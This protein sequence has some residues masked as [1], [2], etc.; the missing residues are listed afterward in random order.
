VRDSSSTRF[1]RA[2]CAHAA[3]Q[4]LHTQCSPVRDWCFRADSV[5]PPQP[6]TTTTTTT[7]TAATTTH[8]P[9]TTRHP[10]PPLL[11]PARLSSSWLTTA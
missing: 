3:T 11:G 5:T 10:P 1:D 8:T 2:P 4:P 6:H 7:T 9:H